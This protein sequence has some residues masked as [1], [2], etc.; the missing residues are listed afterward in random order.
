[1]FETKAPRQRAL[2]IHPLRSDN[3]NLRVPQMRLEEACGLALALDLEVLHSS[4]ETLREIRP[5]TLFGKGKLEIF[6]NWIEQ[7][8]IDVLVIDD[9]ISP[10]QQRN[11]EKQL[12]VKVI[13]RTGLILEIFSLR[14][15]TKEGKLQV[16][17]ARLSYEKSRLV[18]TWT[19]LERQRGGTGKTGGPGERQIEIDRRLI[20]KNIDRLKRELEDVR[21][22]RSLQ[23]GGREKVPFPIIAL[24]GYT[25]AGKSTLF[26][27]ITKANVLAKDLL[28]ATL[29]TVSRAFR[30]PGG[31]E[32]ILSDTVGFIT[33]L[34]HE[35][36]AAF[37]ATLE[38]VADADILLHVRDISSPESDAQKHDVDKILETI[39]SEKE[40]VPAIIEV[41][42]KADLVESDAQESLKIAADQY[43]RQYGTK[44]VL[45][46][47]TKATGLDELFAEIEKELKLDTKSGF[48][49]FLPEHG[50]LRAWL[51]EKGV[52]KSE[53]VRD[54][55]NLVLEIS[56]N[57]NQHS[58]LLARFGK[59]SEVA[60][61]SFS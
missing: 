7:F 35:L 47:A 33:D 3:A 41:W 29:D 36:I 30:I 31:S 1:M 10:V 26:N 60:S 42:N 52:V 17:L 53:T 45:V 11:L 37:R 44:C 18:K 24:V 49:E 13:D 59:I 51:Y 4:V 56:L 28:F 55:G 58:Q 54:N 25:N 39:L 8:E 61:A 22:T 15:R 2:V 48:I 9:A 6:E 57:R 19:H 5:S 14:A 50:K 27:T 12:N 20:N 38:E 16:E 46:S 40:L 43:F 21:R 32:V 23:R 34:P